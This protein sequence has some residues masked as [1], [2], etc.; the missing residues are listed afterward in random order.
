MGE[1]HLKLVQRIK[2]VVEDYAEIPSSELELETRDL[3]LE[4]LVMVIGC[5]SGCG[6]I[7]SYGVCLLISL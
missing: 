7:D 3:E 5:S 2:H 1:L 4:L 6:G